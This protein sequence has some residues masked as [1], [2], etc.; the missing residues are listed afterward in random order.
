MCT[1]YLPLPAQSPFFL[2]GG[3]GSKTI[4]GLRSSGFLQ[5]LK[6]WLP[7]NLEAVASS[8]PKQW[9]PPNLKAVAYSNT[10][11]ASSTH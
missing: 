11:E 6:Q 8:K 7:P 1:H 2:Y 5:T 10:E 3:P 4:T 9:L